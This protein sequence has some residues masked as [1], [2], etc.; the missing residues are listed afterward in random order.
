MKR[1]KVSLPPDTAGVLLGLNFDPEDGGYMI[2]RKVGVFP[3]YTAL[4]TRGQYCTLNNLALVMD[5]THGSRKVRRDGN[6][7]SAAFSLSEYFTPILF[8]LMCSLT[9]FKGRRLSL[10]PL[11]S[12]LFPPFPIS[13]PSLSREA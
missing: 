13:A 11:Q 9:P 4:Q 5:L 10:A 2:L 12:Q 6:L 7:H 3:N 8:P 1:C